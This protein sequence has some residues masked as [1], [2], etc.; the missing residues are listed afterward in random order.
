LNL[1]QAAKRIDALRSQIDEHNYRY[2]V[3]DQPSIPD[4]EYDK[5]MRELQ[6]LESQHPQ[7]ISADSPTQRVGAEPLSAFESVTHRVPMLSL[8]NAF[9]DDE[10]DE[11]DRRVH[12]RLGD[13]DTVIYAAEPKLDGLAISL[14]YE[15]GALVLGATRGDG[16]SG[17]NVTHNVR[18]IEA[19]PLRLRGDDWPEVLE[20]RGEIFMPRAGFEQL[21]QRQRERGEKTFANPRNAAAGSLRQLDPR[22]TAQRPLS[23]FCYGIGEVLGHQ[24]SDSYSGNMAL[25]RN[26][27]L[28]VSPELRL[29]HSRA[30]CHDYVEQLGARRDD[31]A[32]DIDGVVFKV[33]AIEQQQH[34]GFVARA[35]RWAIARKFPAQEQLTVVE[36]I[37][38]QVGRTGALTPV[39]RLKPV[40]VGGVTV[41]NA[42]LHNMDEIERK[43]VRVGDTVI[44]RRAGDVIPEVVGSL[45]ERRPADA[46][47]V[48]LPTQCPVCGSAVIRPAG[49]AV[50]RCS[51]GLFCS[52]QRKE[53]V[54]HFASRKAMDIE[55]LGDK[56]VEQL[57]D[58]Q[59]I[60]D[61]ADLYSLTQE[62]LAGLERMGEKSA[63]NLI[64]ALNASKQTVLGRFLFALGILGIGETMA[65]T[66]AEQLGSLERIEQLRLS[67]LVEIK[68]SQAKNLYRQ[69]EALQL[70]PDTPLHQVAAPDEL[71]W[72]KPIHMQLL[73]ERF[74]TL[75][76]ALQSPPEELANAPSVRIEGVGEVL[77]EKLVAFFA[78][79]HNVE[80]ID[81]LRAAGVHWPAP[82]RQTAGVERTLAGKTF[83]LTGTLSLPRDDYKQQLLARGAKV[84]GSVSGKTD[85]VVAGEAAGSKL[86]KAQQLGVTVIDEAR[87]RAL[88]SDEN[89]SV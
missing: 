34:L 88:L 42:T 87:L 70:N 72:C 19:L 26:W 40:F 37:E 77:A 55:G 13:V 80:V 43:D 20:V 8:D 7:L 41:S 38:F 71:K 46:P 73:A 9:D 24:M 86:S 28:P 5:L 39:A 2:Y 81:K 17:E 63:A 14:R 58:N 83:V 10:F 61:P 51:G 23:F 82:D 66:L 57:V 31:L 75:G 45:P 49:E 1:D 74:D 54:K 65:N 32:Y 33:D 18:T 53:A 36:G 52:A 89:P 85:F 6:L 16:R 47:P 12:D 76:I 3:L 78:Q 29:C 30:Q 35:P 67:D 11:F 68:Q 84:A 22:V 25:L 69:L 15:A 50:A 48:R 56:L 79:P 27:G 4:I 59:L 60:A 62:Q 21:N 44:V 64:A